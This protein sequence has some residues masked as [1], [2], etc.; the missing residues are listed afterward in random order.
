MPHNKKN[1][2]YALLA[3]TLLLQP[4]A[5]AQSTT[6]GPTTLLE[7]L[8]VTARKREQNLQAIGAG[9]SLLSGREIAQAQL[10]GADD[11]GTLIPALNVQAS[12]GPSTSSFNIRGIGTRTF[13]P[14]V[15]PSVSTMLDGVVM[16]RSG[17]AFFDLVDVERVE[18]L[19]G[20]QGTLYGKNASGGV[21][22]VI[23]S[24]PGPEFEGRIS[25]TAI[26]ENEYRLNGTV[27]GPITNNLGY[28]LTGSVVDD[29]GFSQNAFEGTRV[30]GTENFNL[31]GKLLWNVNE[32]LELLWVSDYSEND[33][34]CTLLSL[35]AVLDS[36]NQSVYLDQLLPVIPSASNQNVN[37]D[38]LTFSEVE[39]SGH[40]LTVDWA[41]GNHVL[42]SIT[43]Y[44]EWSSEGIVDLDNLPTNPI[45]LS[46]PG[47]PSTDQDQ[48][49]QELRLASSPASW[50]SYV[51]GAYYFE[52]DIESASRV[53]TA[54]FAPVLPPTLRVANTQVGIENLALF[55]EVNVN[56]TDTLELILGGRYTHD[57]INYNTNVVGT[58]NLVFPPDGSASDSLDDSDFSEK[59]AL[60][61]SLDEQ[62]MLYASYVAG[63][64]GPAFDTSLVARDSFV[65]PET[66]DAWEAGLKSTWF[67]GRLVLNIAAFYAQYKDFQAEASVDD[68]IDDQLPG[69]F[70]VVNAGEVTSKGV[71]IDFI[72]RPTDQW[73]VTGGMAYTDGTIEEF[74]GGNC[75][76][77]QK[78]RGECPLGY[79]D[80]SGGELPYTPKWKLNLATSY[81][82]PIDT[83]GFD[84]VLG[85]NLRS[86]SDILYELSQDEF[87]RQDAYTIV[88][89][90]TA[91][92]G[93]ARPYK[94]TLFVKNVF[95]KN[96]AT[97]I[98]AQGP[99]LIPNAYVH[100]VPKY[101]NRTAGVELTFDF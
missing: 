85:A 59:I 5:H 37:N 29:G 24:D 81:T 60:Q 94:L 14:G 75:S 10:R 70:L 21:I 33:C 9:V 97:L 12:S 36:P 66:S 34:E 41:L 25:A 31:R 8:V 16:G 74:P 44:R 96:Y 62:R 65:K 92:E 45:A 15:E 52:Q 22:H 73:A 18:V 86:Q 11:L 69:N 101:A 54:L 87:T 90:S 99:E 71:E 77:G 38:Q 50:G 23:T 68:N 30:N 88:D 51:V 53:V 35:R 27:S 47:P 17:M 95:D 39:A 19:R 64:K 56:L 32:D 48:F 20:P 82:L 67:D 93:R 89:L 57:D 79:Q 40:A 1:T 61:W 6:A 26:E 49:S 58:D 43:S 13:S 42:T 78:F 7:E 80:L 3:A 83:H 98:Y 76:G 46:F 28:R 4:A 100:R 63:Y 2:R 55:G 72:S 91:I 84:L